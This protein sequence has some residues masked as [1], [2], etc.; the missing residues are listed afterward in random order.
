MLKEICQ[1]WMECH[2]K[3]IILIEMS[4][5]LDVVKQCVKIAS[6]EQWIHVNIDEQQ[7]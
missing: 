3:I 4:T 1:W 5:D 7:Q 2:Q 6:K